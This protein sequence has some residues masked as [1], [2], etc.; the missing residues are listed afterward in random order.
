MATSSPFPLSFKNALQEALNKNAQRFEILVGIDL[1]H[2][3]P[4][5]VAVRPL[6]RPQ[7][8]AFG[9]ASVGEAEA[10]LKQLSAMA[11]N[12]AALAS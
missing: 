6:Q 1:D 8:R 9:F 3:Q 11:D 7:K 12:P 10:F 2:P 4:Y 5:R